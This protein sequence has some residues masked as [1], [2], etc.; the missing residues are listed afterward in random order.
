MPLTFYTHTSN[1]NPIYSI[2]SLCSSPE[3]GIT[4]GYTVVVSAVP[5]G[6][7]SGVGVVFLKVTSEDEGP[8]F[9]RLGRPVEAVLEGPQ[10]VEDEDGEHCTH[11]CH[12]TR[13]HEKNR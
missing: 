1:P 3:P 12:Y 9:V 13:C 7:N 2:S 10:K 11:G 8:C 6:G 4:V 5:G